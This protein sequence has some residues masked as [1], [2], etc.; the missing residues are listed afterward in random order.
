MSIELGQ[1]QEGFQPSIEIPR[2]E[3]GRIRWKVLELEPD[4]LAGFVE[5]EIQ[6]LISNEVTITKAGLN[7]NGM[8]NL[9]SGIN[10]YYPGGFRGLK[11]KLGIA[12][13]HP[14]RCWHDPEVIEREA[15]RLTSEGIGIS[16]K[17]LRKN[18]LSGFAASIHRFYPGG[19]LALK[20]ALGITVDSKPRGY[21]DDPQVVEAETRKLLEVGNKLTQKSIA[22][23]GVSSL[24]AAIARHYPGGLRKF[25]QDL[26]VADESKPNGYWTEDQIR[27]EAKDFFDQHGILRHES[28]SSYGMSGLSA[29]ITNKYPGGMQRLKQDLGVAI[30]KKY[31]H[32]TAEVIEEDAF[33]VYQE[34]GVL[35]STVLVGLG[36]NDLMIAIVRK[37][38]GGLSGLR[39]KL[40]IEKGRKHWTSE[41]V[42]REVEE[43]FRE[44]GDISY[45]LLVDQHRYDLI[46]AIRTYYPGGFQ[47]LR[48]NLG[49]VPNR[50]PN[51]YWTAEQIEK[52]ISDFYME[53]GKVTQN[54]LIDNRRFD[55]MAAISQYYPGR[56]TALKRKLGI[57]GRYEVEITPEEA[58]EQLRR[59]LEE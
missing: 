12:T 27:N 38:P 55:L 48:E 15:R 8:S 59:L 30:T 58:N 28:L 29:A 1:V 46:N 18:G 3:E 47:S 7:A 20:E 52:E 42:E 5:S 57:P 56:L 36:R 14:W 49:L 44:S 21:W 40:G 6:T 45:S 11:E 39:K 19:S 9:L 24:G 10:R 35:T 34:A 37:Y 23:A 33:K 25:R 17:S 16:D 2:D 50:K 51:G 13:S 4:R 41:T 26:G 32:W 43:F 54:L 53:F 31:N 22:D